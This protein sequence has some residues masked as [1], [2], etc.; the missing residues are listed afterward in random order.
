MI[1]TEDVQSAVH[2]QPQQ[3]FLRGH[4]LAFGIGARNL[5]ADVDITDNGPAAA[6]AAETERNHVGGTAMSQIALIEL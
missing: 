1:V 3:L 6:M 2:D 4:A 5:G